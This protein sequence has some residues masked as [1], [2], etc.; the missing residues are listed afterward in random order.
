M[1]S[2][3]APAVIIS[4]ADPSTGLP[5]IGTRRDST[6]P[7]A[8]ATAAHRQVTTPATATEP[9]IVPD[10]SPTPASPMASPRAGFAPNRARFTAASMISSHSGTVAIS[11]D[12]SPD[13]TVRSATDS[14]PLA[15]S[16]SAPTSAQPSHCARLG[17]SPRRASGN[18]ISPATRYLVPAISSGGRLSTATRI[19]KYVLPHTTQTTSSAA[20]PL[21]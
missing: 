20:H 1:H 21:P 4:I 3:T 14:A 19:A 17:R 12:A 15:P 16:S 5:G 13:G 7:S 10:S 9:V 18:R 2:S 8:Q 11:S 6:V